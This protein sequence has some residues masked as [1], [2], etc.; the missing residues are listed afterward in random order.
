MTPEELRAQKIS[1]VAGELGFEHP[2]WSVDKCV[3]LAT[4]AADEMTVSQTRAVDIDHLN[5]LLRDRDRLWCQAACMAL[6]IDDLN[7]LLVQFQTLRLE[8]T[9]EK[10]DLN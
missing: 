4:R 5:R 2:D 7:K 8:K 10:T 9:D 6:S 3:A 1:W